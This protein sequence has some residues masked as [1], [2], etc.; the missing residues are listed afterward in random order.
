MANRETREVNIKM[1]GDFKKV[2]KGIDKTNKKVTNFKDKAL[3]GASMMTTKLSQGLGTLGGRFVSLVPMLGKVSLS[4][5]TLRGAIMSTGI[6]ALVLGVLALRSAFT[7]S[8]EGQN[9][10][11]KAMAMIGAVTGQLM[12]KLADFGEFIIGIFENPKQ[13]M[14]DF[15]DALKENITNRFEGLMNL[16]PSLGQAVT[17]LFD[18]EFSKAG[19]IATDAVGQVVLG[20]DSVTDSLNNAVKAGKDFVAET[21]SEVDAMARIA[22]SRANID[23]K[24]RQ[25]N[26]DRA[27]ADAEISEL[28]SKVEDAENY[29]ALER[30][31]FSKEA[32]A[33]QSELI[34]REEAL[35]AEKLKN[36]LAENALGKSTK[37]DLDEANALE[38]ELIQKKTALN[39]FNKLQLA[40]Q[41]A[42]R[43][44]A[45][46]AAK[47]DLAEENKVRDEAEKARDKYEQEQAAKLKAKID[48]QK[49][50][51][52]ALVEKLELEKLNEEE[53][54]QRD[55]ERDLAKLEGLE[56]YEQAKL[57][58]MAKYAKMEED[59]ENKK[60]EAK[61]A[62]L[63][64]SAQAIM[65][66]LATVLGQQ[67]KAGKAFAIANATIDVYSGM[68]KA[69]KDETIPNTFARIAAM[70]AV[71]TKG[72]MAVKNIMS[73][74][75]Q[76]FAGGGGSAPA[77]Q[78]P[79]FN[80]IGQ[81]SAGEQLI[82]GA[83]GD[84]NQQPIQAYVVES[85]MTSQQQMSR[86]VSENA[87]L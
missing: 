21:Q 49:K 61:Q 7:R 52:D 37:A 76:G 3:G 78:A 19:K 17:A 25:L 87:S 44:E 15:K 50:E 77:V 68:T 13:A 8:E 57:D 40:R 16:I 42:L 53:K 1:T 48:L 33:K 63:L 28:R 11:A 80:V 79:S 27:K 86:N 70:T 29:T 83:I 84:S 31:E 54:L 45:N 32:Q 59:L 46:A 35:I 47:R 18:G 73:T 60:A 56:G 75:V 71:A 30:L 10:M 62:I 64:N 2:N 51:A 34:K 20:V 82:A 41:K 38:V 24:Q 12:D 14:I 55:F 26:L 69:L 81:T 66:S 9:K 4:F 65:G 43:A 72:F 67:N 5:K 6:G 22:D 74:N 85:Q 23:K 58:I 36:K 39:N